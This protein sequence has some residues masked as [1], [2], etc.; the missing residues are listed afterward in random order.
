MKTALV[1][2]AN[3]GIGFE[4]V[5]QLL[6]LGYN[7]FLSSRNK[8]KGI[9]AVE[10]LSDFNDK[11]HFLQMDVSS[12]ESIISAAKQ[13][14]K[15]N[16][17]LDVLVNNA[18]IL[19]DKTNITSMGP[20]VFTETF[21]TNTLGVILVI[22][23]F[24]D[25]LKNGSKIINVS[26]GWGALNEMLDS[27]PAYSISKTALNAVTKQFAAT[28]SERN[29]SVNSV[30]P[31]WVKT[32]MGGMDANRSVEKGAETIIWLCE[33]DQESITGKF[34]RDKKEISW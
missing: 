17:E 8:E 9:L 21:N 31:G 20:G 33:S 13:L 1:T 24:L 32:D 23:H 26:S 27:S 18:A 5:R 25:L 19:I 11:I 6:G 16:Y 15:N 2:G 29:I 28:L 4:I 30:C 3:K 14:R 10:K 7:V 34:L 22:Q 12:E